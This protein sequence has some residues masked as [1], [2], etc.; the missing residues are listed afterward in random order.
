MKLKDV[1]KRFSMDADGFVYRI[2]FYKNDEF[3]F[4]SKVHF[5]QDN[6]K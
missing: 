1:D 2:E 4:M 6:K 3:C 5:K